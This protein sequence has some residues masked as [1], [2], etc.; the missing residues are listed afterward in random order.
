MPVFRFVYLVGYTSHKVAKPVFPVVFQFPPCR[1]AMSPPKPPRQT[2][3]GVSASTARTGSSQGNTSH[4]GLCHGLALLTQRSARSPC[5][6]AGEQ[7]VRALPHAACCR[8]VVSPLRYGA[9]LVSELCPPPEHCAHPERW[10]GPAAQRRHKRQANAGVWRGEADPTRA[11]H[12]AVF[13]LR[14][15]SY[16]CLSDV[17]ESEGNEG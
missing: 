6:G 13:P 10:C 8:A 9:E 14:N 16:L 5:A 11:S 4:R 15:T 3:P 7:Q 2:R 1:T 17:F 12:R